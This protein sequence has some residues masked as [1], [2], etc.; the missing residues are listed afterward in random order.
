MKAI[1]RL[2]TISC[3]IVFILLA[4]S[5]TGCSRGPS[6]DT[7]LDALPNGARNY[8][9]KIENS[10]TRKIGDETIYLYEVRLYDEQGYP[11]ASVY[12][13]TVKFVKRGKWKQYHDGD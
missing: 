10:Y 9:L 11:P 13:G 7:I 2:P 1:R 3:A 4:L 8:K 5:S 12:S 6:K